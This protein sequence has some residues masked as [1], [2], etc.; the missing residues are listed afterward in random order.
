MS[1]YLLGKYFIQLNQIRES[2]LQVL[3]R[4]IMSKANALFILIVTSFL[5]ASALA[6]HPYDQRIMNECKLNQRLAYPSAQCNDVFHYY[7]AP[8]IANVNNAVTATS[9]KKGL[10]IGSFNIYLLGSGESRF[11]DLGAIAHIMEQWDVVGVSELLN[12]TG[13]DNTYNK[14]LLK[15]Q[16]RLISPLFSTDNPSAPSSSSGPVKSILTDSELQK[17]QAYWAPGYLRLLE[18]L[19]ALN[20]EAGWALVLSPYIQSENFELAGFFFKSSRVSLI[21]TEECKSHK[22][23]IMIEGTPRE[24]GAKQGERGSIPLIVPDSFLGCVARFPHE[25]EMKFSRRPFM[26][27]FD[28]NGSAFTMLTGHYRFRAGDTVTVAGRPQCLDQ[29]QKNL[30]EILDFFHPQGL[31]LPYLAPAEIS[32]AIKLLRDGET[33]SDKDNQNPRLLQA[34]TFPLE[35]LNERQMYSDSESEIARYYETYQTLDLVRNM[36]LKGPYKDV[37]LGADFNLE[38][39]LKGYWDLV[40][41]PMNPNG[42]AQFYQLTKEMSEDRALAKLAEENPMQF[43]LSVNEKSSVGIQG[44]NSAYDHFVVPVGRFAH[45]R[46][47]KEQLRGRLFNFS[48]PEQKIESDK[49]AGTIMDL[50]NPYRVADALAIDSHIAQLNQDFFSRNIIDK[51]KFV[52][53]G[54]VEK[55]RREVALDNE[56]IRSRVYDNRCD[57]V[58][59]ALTACEAQNIVGQ[60]SKSSDC[61][62]ERSGAQWCETQAGQ[63]YTPKFLMQVLSDHMPIELSCDEVEI[64]KAVEV[65]SEIADG[66][67]SG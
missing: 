40:L 18:Q 26:A 24:F 15:A 53:C 37:L 63:A 14:K 5:S 12:W 19:Q 6:Y 11:K 34:L 64:E 61:L 7:P 30:K 60:N 27:S 42:L 62:E 65:V 56:K 46:T 45:C 17:M 41:L 55:C 58:V 54:S 2:E 16:G 39:K 67:A 47:E 10:K 13:I 52:P 28:Y 36:S 20:P 57:S 50:L 33:P 35:L 22:E 1:F 29:C 49:F 25:V 32:R 43:E 66:S 51:G 59:A 3:T 8:A 9:S 44:P 23:R 4:S 31:Q 48:S 21:E 38:F